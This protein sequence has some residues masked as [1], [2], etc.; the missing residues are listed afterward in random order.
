MKSKYLFQ[1]VALLA[2]LCS[3]FGASQPVQAKPQQTVQIVMRN[4][5]YWDATYSGSVNASRYEKWPFQLGETSVFTI[6]ASASSGAAPLI[7]LLDVNGNEISTLV[8]SL[9]TTQPAGE[10]YILIAP[11]ADSS[12][13]YNLTIR[14]EVTL[15]FVSTVV[16]PKSIEV[17]KT[18]TA[19][20]SL[21]N[22]PATGYTSV[23][24]T[25][26]YNP[27]MAEVSN[28]VAGTDLFGA[29]AAVAINGPQNGSFIIAVAG[30]NGNKVVASGAA[31]TF[32]L[33]GLQVGQTPVEC[34]ARVSTG[35]NTLADI[36]FDPD[37]LSIID[38]QGKLE[39]KV[40]ASKAVTI[41]VRNASNAEVA[42]VTSN[43]GVFSLPLPAGTYTA[44]ASANGF[45]GAQTLDTAKIT[46]V[47]GKT[48]TMPAV[49]LLA[50][51]IDNNGVIDQFDAMTIGMSYNTALPAAADLNNDGTINVLDLELLAANY[52]KAGAVAWQ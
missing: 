29:D 5:A 9:N 18:S 23:E 12:V 38:Q 47:G 31:F 15:P 49:R 42:S 45:L 52:R 41:S 34:K 30:T 22:V 39:G 7:S 19:I 17:G 21:S 6:T 16:D 1:I 40:T 43:D 8:G 4:L 27:A 13:S 10:Y 44:L 35:S 37:T 14:K 51:D 3:A 2:I 28:I 46:I 20:V 33:K 11:S 32:S 26:T 25:C 50:G 48:I 36:L 24:F